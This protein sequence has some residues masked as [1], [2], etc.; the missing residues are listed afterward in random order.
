VNHS[1]LVNTARKWLISCGCGVVITELSCYN[2]ANE[3]PD[4]VGWKYANSTQVECKV[5]VNDFK[6]DMKKNSR[7]HPERGYGDHRYYMVPEGLISVDKIP[8]NWGLLEVTSKGKVKIIKLSGKFPKSSYS[9]ISMLLS[10]M[11]RCEI[12]TENVKVKVYP[13]VSTSQTTIS[14]CEGDEEDFSRF[15]VL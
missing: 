5:S 3:I 12:N 4:A 15:R 6:S 1:D 8:E 11:R 9:E 7:V 14:I 10:A 2:W 13:N